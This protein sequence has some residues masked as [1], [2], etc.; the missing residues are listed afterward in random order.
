MNCSLVFARVTDNA[1]ESHPVIWGYNYLVAIKYILSTISHH[2]WKKFAVLPTGH[3]YSIERIIDDYSLFPFYRPFLSPDIAHSVAER[4]RGNH[5]TPI[6]G[7]IGRRLSRIA[8]IHHLRY[9]PGCVEDDRSHF[10]ETYWHR[11]HQLEGIETCP[12]HHAT[13]VDSKIE[14]PETSRPPQ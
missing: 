7:L 11:S 6:H 14:I 4:L 3:G 13:L 12:V 1:L 5:Q 2:T 9:C 10:G 8:K